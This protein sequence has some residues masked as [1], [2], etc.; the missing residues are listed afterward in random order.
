VLQARE[1]AAAARA[2]QAD[3]PR[4]AA[5][6]A[7]STA[8][9]VIDQVVRRW[10][11]NRLPAEQVQP[12]VAARAKLDQTAV[13]A[14]TANQLP[15]ADE[16]LAEAERLLSSMLGEGDLTRQL[17]GL[18]ARQKALAEETRAFVRANLTKQPD[19]AG[20]ALQANLAQRAQDLAA[21]VADLEAKVLARE[22]GT[23]TQ[24]QDLVRREAPAAR[25]RT[26]AGDLGTIDRRA[27]AVEGQQAAL[28]SLARLLERLRGG[29]AAHGLAERA[30]TLAAEQEK[31]AAALDA[32]KRP[33]DLAQQQTDLARETDR[34]RREV[35]ANPAAGRLGAA[36]A[37]QDSASQ[38]MSGGDAS[39]AKRDA[40]AAAGLLRE[41]QKQLG[42]ED[43]D[44]KPE[45]PDLLALLRDIHTGQAALVEAL[46][47]LDGKLGTNELGFDD[48]RQLAI[49]TRTQAD[50]AL[51]LKADALSKLKAAPIAAMAVGRVG[52]AMEATR[53]HLAKPALGVAGVRLARTALAELGRLIDIA[54]SPP[55]SAAGGN[56]SGGG[57][58]KSGSK[59][60][61]ELSLLAAMQEELAQLTAAGRPMDLAAAQQD[62]VHLADAL[63]RGTRPDTRPA[64]LVQRVQRAMSAA[65][66]YLGQD[67]RGA[68]TRNEQAAAVAAIRRLLSEGGGGD[69]GGGGGG[70]GG[71]SSASTPP[72]SGG[73]GRD[74]S[75]SG[76]DS[77]GQGQGKV[78]GEGTQGQTVAPDNGKGE[79]LNLP[80]ARR[81]QLREARQQTLTP[82]QLQVFARYL[83]LLED[84][85]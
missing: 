27:K 52:M 22:G 10:G 75:A 69:S 41:A 1:S 20:K 56:G 74:P 28:G 82:R 68:A 31:L 64:E 36:G 48:R 65:H 30:G 16:A 84:G 57:G 17:E 18:I 14:L 8:V 60:R 77:Q 25:L 5:T 44:K 81:E 26:A 70:G 49:H 7:A 46:T 32:G 83:E 54:S 67:D 79:W 43:P 2:S 59:P 21:Q 62:L 9:T 50:L 6:Q 61:A 71:G 23:W 15:A 78:A 38:A 58:G 53:A 55:P 85:K 19:A 47:T 12:A 34:L 40:V 51:R 11:W 45:N 63:S 13:P 42:N 3:G 76:G 4:R 33:A 66:W 80:P 37:A 39:A 35:G 24:A 73:A 29:D 72:P